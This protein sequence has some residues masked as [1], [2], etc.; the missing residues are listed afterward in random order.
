MQLH[1][2]HNMKRYYPAVLDEVKWTT[3]RKGAPGILNFTVVKDEKLAFS[4]GDLVRF[5]YDQDNV[6]YGFIFTK[7]RTKE[8]V[9]EVTAYD[10]LRYLKNKD[11]CMYENKKAS[12]VI[13]MLAEDFRLQ[14]GNIEDTKYV[15]P[16]RDEDNQTLF[17]IINK[18]LD[19]TFD[20]TGNIYTLYDNYGKLTLKNMKT[21]RLNLLICDESGEDFDYTSSIDSNTY[22]RIKLS[23]DNEKTGKRDIFVAQNTDTINKWGVLQY[24]ASLS[25]VDANSKE[26]EVKAKANMMTAAMLKNYNNVTRSLSLKNL[27]GDTRARAGSSVYVHMNLGDIILKNYMLITKATHIYSK[28][29]HFMDLELIGGGIYGQ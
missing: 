1:I 20:T 12:E 18:A 11:T 14:A 15:I 10:Q 8:N 13:K 29:S 22:N 19:L 3:E 27:F 28:D 6:F 4:E 25:G 17:D 5:Q 23:Y 26:E 2:E 7:K 16:S 9:I 21:M 24:Y